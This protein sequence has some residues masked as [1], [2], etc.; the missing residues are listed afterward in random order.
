MFEQYSLGIYE[1][2]FPAAMDWEHRFAAA[3]SVGFDF[4]ELSIDVSD[5][6]LVRLDWSLETCRDFI[7]LQHKTGMRVPTLC[8]SGMRRYPIGSPCPAV[9]DNGML[10]ISKAIRL[11][12]HLGIRVVQLAGYDVYAPDVSTEQSAALFHQNIGRALIEASTY[13]VI[14]AI[15][16]MEVAFA[17]SLTSLM[18]YVSYYDSPYLQLY[19]DI[20]NLSAMGKDLKHELHAAQGHIAAMHI[21]DTVAGMCRDIPF[22][23]GTVNFEEAFICI[24]ENR[25]T[26]MLLLE[27]WAL[28][29]G[30]SL[31]ACSDAYSFITA[32][33]K[34]AGLK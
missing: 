15:E 17:D 16:N 28:P 14:L 24:A 33:M 32:K 27:M 20:G 12:S 31:K 2:A 30:D 23:E 13:G 26:G 9:R 5:E 7:R 6:R 21:K 8:L 4:L 1:K 22:G 29:K 19:A 34:C 11:A 10:L 18:E 25:Y 3:R